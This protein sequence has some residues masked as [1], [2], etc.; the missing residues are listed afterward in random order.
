[1][2]ELVKSPSFIRGFKQGAFISPFRVFSRRSRFSASLKVLSP[3]VSTPHISTTSQDTE[4]SISEVHR[5]QMLL[6]LIS[7]S[8]TRARFSASLTNTISLTPLT[9]EFSARRL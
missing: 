8:E 4:P 6:L 5:G 3:E 7:G 1:M 9:R 2:I